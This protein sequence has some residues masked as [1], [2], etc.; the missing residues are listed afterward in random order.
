MTAAA[1]TCLMLLATFAYT[2]LAPFPQFSGWKR[3]RAAARD[4]VALQSTP[5]SF[6]L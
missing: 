5:C 1:A 6:Y 4:K 3:G 2:G